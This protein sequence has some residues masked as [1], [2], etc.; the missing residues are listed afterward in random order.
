MTAFDS[1][2]GFTAANTYNGSGAVQT[3]NSL[4]TV[5]DLLSQMWP[6]VA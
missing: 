4:P 3:T 2:T 1:Q 6:T 5:A